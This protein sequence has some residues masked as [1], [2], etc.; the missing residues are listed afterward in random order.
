MAKNN[1]S[2]ETGR[3]D[4]VRSITKEAAIIGTAWDFIAVMLLTIS[5]ISMVYTEFFDFSLTGGHWF[6]LALFVLTLSVIRTVIDD[7]TKIKHPILIHIPASAAGAFLLF[8][9]I[10]ANFEKLELGVFDVIKS[11]ITV[12][13]RIYRQSIVIPSGDMDYAS[14]SVL[15]IMVV[16]VFLATVFTRI[17]RLKF[18]MLLIPTASISVLMMVGLAPAWWTLVIMLVGAYMLF[19][20]PKH[21]GMVG[22]RV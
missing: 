17:S 14:F 22:L 3:S 2:W 6:L 1:I 7:M 13:N 8:I 18:P 15:V 10:K 16:L 21:T 11:Y 9:F 4:E 20:P 19:L 5:A 12:Y